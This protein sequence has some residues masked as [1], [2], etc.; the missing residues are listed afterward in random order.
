M[1]S[2]VRCRRALNHEACCSASPTHSMASATKSDAARHPVRGRTSNTISASAKTSGEKRI[3]YGKKPHFD[4]ETHSARGAA[5]SFLPRACAP[6]L[7]LQSPC[8]GTGGNHAIGLLHYLKVALE[9]LEHG[10]I[11]A[12]WAALLILCG[13][14][15]STWF[16]PGSCIHRLRT[17]WHHSH[18]YRS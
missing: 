13:A 2:R 5:T 1:K 16:R 10:A 8:R 15:R 12:R 3:A 11:F 17:R 7:R 9:K 6:I 4:L 18:R 14:S